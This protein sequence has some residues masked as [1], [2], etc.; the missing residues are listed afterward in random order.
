MGI[1]NYYKIMNFKTTINKPINKVF[2]LY[3]DK[4]KLLNWQKQLVKVEELSSKTKLIHKTVILFET[5]DS[6]KEPMSFVA[7]YEHTR[8]GDTKMFHTATT[9]FSEVDKHTTLVEIDITQKFVG[10]LPNIIM[11]LMVGAVKKHHKKVL[12]NFKI[13]AENI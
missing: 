6:I 5:I 9:T 11:P 12:N 1:K 2:T 13:F 10:F 3:T 7:T 4:S 8:K